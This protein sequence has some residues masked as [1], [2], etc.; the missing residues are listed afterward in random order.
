MHVFCFGDFC[1][2]SMVSK[3]GG[4][5]CTIIALYALAFSSMLTCNVW[6]T[7]EMNNILVNGNTLYTT[8]IDNY[9]NG[10]P[11]YIAHDQLDILHSMD[12][13][14][15]ILEPT[16]YSN[17]FYGAVGV[18]PDVDSLAVNLNNGLEIA[19][20]LSNHVLMTFNELS[21]AAVVQNGQYFIFDSHA[22][23]AWGQMCEYGTS[24]LLHFESFNDLM[25]YLLNV[26]ND[27]MFNLSPVK[28][29]TEVNSTGSKGMDVDEQNNTTDQVDNTSKMDDQDTWHE[30]GNSDTTLVDMATSLTN[31]N[32]SRHDDSS[33]TNIGN[34]YEM[35]SLHHPSGIRIKCDD[36]RKAMNPFIDHSYH[37]RYYNVASI[38]HDHG[39]CQNTSSDSNFCGKHYLPYEDYI[40]Q[41]LNQSCAMCHRL[42]FRN[43]CIFKIVD[44]IQECFCHTCNLKTRNGEISS[45]AWNNNMDPG[46]V[47]NEIRVLKKIERRFIAL[48]HVFMT[49]FL[50]P[51]NQQL[52]TKGI[53]INIPAS[54][55]E[56]INSVGPSPGV[57]IS[58]ESRSNTDHDLSHL[59]SPERIYKALL[60]LKNNNALYAGFDLPEYTNSNENTTVCSV[61]DI[62]E[63]I[64]INVDEH[65][66]ASKDV[67]TSA[68]NFQHIRLPRVN[69][70][71]VNA[72]EMTSGEEMCFPWLF[73][74]G[75]GGYTDVHERDSMFPSM[76]PKA[77][78]MGKDD[79]FRKDMMYLLHYANVY[80]RRMLL[81]SVNIHMKMKV[82][83]NDITVSQLQNFDYK[84]NSYMFMSQVRGCAGYF[85]NKLI[86][87]LSY[88]RNLGNPHLFCT[89]SPDEQSYPELHAFLKNMS[90]EKACEQLYDG[91]SFSS[92]ISDD[93]L[94]VIQH[95]E[96][97]MDALLKFIINGPL[98]P[99]G[100]KVVDYFIRREFQQRGSVH[101]HVLFWLEKFPDLNDGAA[102]VQFIDKVISTEIPDENIDPELHELVKRY[103]THIH[104][105]KYC[106]NNRRNKCRFKFPFPPCSATHLVPIGVSHVDLPTNAF[107]RTK[108]SANAAYI[109]AYNPI[110][111]RHWR[112]NTDI[113]LVNGAHGIAMYVCYYL[114]KAEPEE[115]KGELSKLIVNVLNKTPDMPTR[116]RLMK[117]G[118]T[119]L[120][121]RKMGCHEA[122]FKALGIDF[123]TA[124]RRVV[125][126]NTQVPEKRYRVLKRKKDLEKLPSD[127][128]EIFQTNIVDYYYNRPEHLDTWC[129]YSFAQWYQI[130]S[131]D[132]KTDRAC[133]R[134]HIQKFQKVMK[135][136]T[137]AAVI[138][139]CKFA[140]ASP[141]YFYSLLMLCMPHRSSD[142]ISIQTAREVF[143]EKVTNGVI[144]MQHLQN[145]NL[146]EEIEIAV[147]SLRELGNGDMDSD[148]DNEEVEIDMF[149]NNVNETF[150]TENQFDHS[151]IRSCDILTVDN[152]ST[153]L[154]NLEASCNNC[155]DITQL[156]IEQ[157][158]VFDYVMKNANI[159]KQVLVFCTGPGGTGK[160]FLIR[161]LTQHL[162]K[163]FAKQQGIRPVL[164]A[165]PTGICSKNINGVTLHSL[166]KLPIDSGRRSYRALG[167]QAMNNLRNTFTGVTHLIIDEISMVSS[168]VLD[169][170]H[171][172]LCTVL[173]NSIPF[174]GLSILAFGDFYQLQPVKGA[175]AF[176]NTMLWHLFEPFFLLQSVRHAT[177]QVFSDLCKNVRL[178][179]LTSNDINLLKSRVVDATLPPYNSAPHIYPHLEQVKKFNENQQ[180]LL[181]S[182]HHNIIAEH[183]YTCGCA[184]HGSKVNSEHIP[185]DD[186]DCGG[187]PSNLRVSIGTKV[188]LLKNLMTKHGLVNGADGIV[189]GFEVDASNSVT[190]IYVTFNDQ[191]VAPMLQL[192][193]RNNAIAIE[194]YSVEFLFAGHAIT[195]TMFPLLPASALTIHKMQGSTKDCI[196]VN[197]GSKIFGHGMAYVAI[198]RCR[199][200]NGLAIEEL[201]IGKITSCPQVKKEYERLEQ[202]ARDRDKQFK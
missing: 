195:R 48:I 54:P 100:S 91:Y 109:N 68:I 50:L 14:G 117:I 2:G 144:D 188:I 143:F 110:I 173:S 60:W 42:L 186:R 175:Y 146:I 168:Q 107:Y 179:S 29:V 5:Q 191:N 41:N 165:G 199:T 81:S 160:S 176:Q 163:S 137:R 178:G 114:N 6:N 83:N 37:N 80:E 136:R 115:L 142:E 101:Y 18:H 172:Q 152:N 180:R 159:K 34:N 197:L 32:S 25:I 139:T 89:F 181:K 200:L 93:P 36:I 59:I 88:I 94:R 141:E 149:T 30:T 97:R 62:E 61:P 71:I 193:D 73:P 1:Q 170:I 77:R 189:S 201:D 35:Y 127:S 78:F 111:T 182:K 51:Q 84:T 167:S 164:L 128:S 65:I 66:P 17:L 16:I 124:S 185:D 112:G 119:V 161:C 9:M 169:L 138:R 108:R 198:S 90:Y 27:Q 183:S 70:N 47:P 15:S 23:D 187:I 53:A 156:N 150:D 113:K 28:F 46:I 13:M 64:A 151:D 134:I 118:S 8:Y 40:Q 133:N 26:Y 12:I 79:R 86:D 190:L 44:G 3:Y 125:L 131:N 129:L 202:K 158:V 99:F 31:N 132:I 123:V 194:R 85:K 43:K 82:N 166:L 92:D 10:I 104:Y 87:L 121:T 145:E 116:A 69:G 147:Q 22:R 162:C 38:S 126:L 4:F 63:C 67:N 155:V 174:G 57:F 95:L 72:Y 153:Y 184:N 58:F 39:Y 130:S 56:I 148:D 19:F 135:K 171:N 102:V 11:Q 96:R 120:R 140:R 55:V 157:K 103:Q 177:D 105:K 49:V 196:V 33:V 122:A 21:V 52:G 24:V 192:S 20:Q 76:Y 75:K 45:I 106:L 154:H 74:Y 98:L 7:N